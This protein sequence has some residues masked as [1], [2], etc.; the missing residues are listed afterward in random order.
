MRKCLTVAVWQRCTECFITLRPT[1]HY[2]SLC[3]SQYWSMLISKRFCLDAICLDNVFSFNSL[4]LAGCHLN[5]A[6][7][8]EHSSKTA[9]RRGLD[10]LGISL[11][12]FR[13]PLKWDSHKMS[14]EANNWFRVGF[15]EAGGRKNIAI[16]RLEPTRQSCR[17]SFRCLTGDSAKSVFLHLLGIITENSPSSTFALRKRKQRQRHACQ[18]QH[19][20]GILV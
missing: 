16:P 17:L 1:R 3:S 15:E 4:C 9:F 10:D 2:T 14:N 5:S 18:A 19:K 11:L 7:P 20:S 12:K 6:H 13:D 8:D